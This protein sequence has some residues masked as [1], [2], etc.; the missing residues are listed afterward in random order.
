M[1]KWL[2]PLV[3]VWVFPATLIGLLP[4]PIVWVQGGRAK[5][6]RGAIEIQGGIVTGWLKHGLPLVGGGAAA[7]TLGHVIWG[8]DDQCL[9]HCRD[10]EHVHVRQYERWGPLFIPAYFTFSFLAWK[11]GFDPYL[12]NP[13]EVEAFGETDSPIL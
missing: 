13:F 12:D 4:L 11:R 5:L 7:M 8:R 1:R 3:Y 10:H 9:S 6:I 2:R